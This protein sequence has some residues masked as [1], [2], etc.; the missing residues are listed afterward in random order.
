MDSGMQ[1]S[2]F[3]KHFSDQTTAKN[4]CDMQHAMSINLV[5]Q[6]KLTIEDVTEDKGII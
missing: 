4:T 2:Y 1:S 6:A 3:K 5:L